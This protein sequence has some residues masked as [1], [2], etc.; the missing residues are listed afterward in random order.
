MAKPLVVQCQYCKHK[1]VP[2]QV[3]PVQCPKCRRLKPLKEE[4]R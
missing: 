4:G 2:R 3:N 1:W